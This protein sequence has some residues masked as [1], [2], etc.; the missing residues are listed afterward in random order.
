MPDKDEKI[1][2]SRW[3]TEL[4]PGDNVPLEHELYTRFVAVQATD[5]NGHSIPVRY[6][7]LSDSRLQLFFDKGVEG[8]ATV[9]LVG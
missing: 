6:E 5:V 8:P 3:A 2:A 7:V 4:E 9:V 1:P